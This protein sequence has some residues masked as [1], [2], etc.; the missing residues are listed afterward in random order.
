MTVNETPP[1]L[2]QLEQWLTLATQP[3][4]FIG[5]LGMLIVSGITVVDVLLRWLGV[6]RVSAMNEIVAMTFAVAVS[7]CVPA[8]LA[9]G[10]NLKIDIFALM[11]TTRATRR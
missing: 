4:A 10:V 11:I 2:V 8:G 1:V 5:V 3:I 6:P 9:G 7:A